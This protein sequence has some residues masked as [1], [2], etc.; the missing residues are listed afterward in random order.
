M[1]EQRYPFDDEDVCLNGWS[2]ARGLA[3]AVIGGAIFA[4]L[5]VA[6]LY[7]VVRTR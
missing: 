6:L 3:W 7:L 5:T 4:G 2:V 1:D